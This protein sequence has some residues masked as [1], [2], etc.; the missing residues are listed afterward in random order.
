MIE[1]IKTIKQGSPEWFKYRCGSIGAS[2]LNRII[3]SKGARSSSRKA[4]MYELAA[5]VFT[6]E[7]TESYSNQHMENGIEREEE[8]RMVFEFEHREVEEVALIKN[9]DIKGAHCSPDGVLIGKEEGSELKNV[10]PK[11]QVKYLDKGVLPIG[12]KLQCQFSLFI[13]GWELWH[14]FSYCPGFKSFYIPV[15]RDEMLIRTI[16]KE[17]GLFIEELN[18]LVGKLKGE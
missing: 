6:G 4:Y 15:K 7:K 16:K 2:S 1:V 9:P 17:V 18:K 3:T 11:T 5:E 13:T 12:Y 10:I 14:F 8:S